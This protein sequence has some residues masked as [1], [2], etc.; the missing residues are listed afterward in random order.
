MLMSNEQGPGPGNPPSNCDTHLLSQQGQVLVLMST[1]SVNSSVICP[2]SRVLSDILL[3]HVVQ[4]LCNV[5]VIYA[6]VVRGS[7][8]Q[9]R[10]LLFLILLVNTTFDLPP[11]ITALTVDIN[12]Y[13][14]K[15]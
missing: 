15:T 4:H 13:S 12:E 7:V 2:N 5:T 6:L 14:S 8:F 11:C 3:F 10:C 9:I 1:D